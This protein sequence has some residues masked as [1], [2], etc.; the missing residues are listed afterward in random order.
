MQEQLPMDAA[1][2]RELVARRL[3]LRHQFNRQV[4]SKAVE[5]VND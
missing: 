4:N 1:L 5:L 2:R 3:L